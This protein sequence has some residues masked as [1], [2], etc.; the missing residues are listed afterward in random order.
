M[1][2]NNQY[3]SKNAEFIANIL[4]SE[5]Q[6]TNKELDLYTSSQKGDFVSL[7]QLLNKVE[8]KSHI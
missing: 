8:F 6:I 2:E 4:K 7:S 1:K 5:G 3:Y